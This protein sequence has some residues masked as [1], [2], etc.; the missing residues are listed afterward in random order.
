MAKVPILSEILHF[1]NYKHINVNNQQ[2]LPRKWNGDASCKSHIREKKYCSQNVDQLCQQELRWEHI[3]V[4][5]WKINVVSQVLSKLF[6]ERRSCYYNWKKVQQRKELT[7]REKGNERANEKKGQPH[8]S[9][10][11]EKN[12]IFQEAI[13]S[14]RY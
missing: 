12:L 2:T 8:F 4:L 13:L 3:P 6:S 7:K 11:L 9:T 10:H 1:K 14:L 5:F